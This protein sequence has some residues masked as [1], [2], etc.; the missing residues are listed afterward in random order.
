MWDRLPR[1]TLP[2]DI[3]KWRKICPGHNDIDPPLTT[4]SDPSPAP[5]FLDRPWS[6]MI[7]YYHSKNSKTYLLRN[8][9]PIIRSIWILFF[10]INE[11]PFD[12]SVKI[13]KKDY[14]T[15]HHQKVEWKR[16]GEIWLRP[17]LFLFLTN[18]R[19]GFNRGEMMSI[20]VE[21]DT[22]RPSDEDDLALKIKT[23]VNFD[24]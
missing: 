6:V 5:F 20:D 4:I 21:M 18:H 10:F 15:L 22:L 14:I 24:R 9:D 13:W 11:V 7:C 16:V 1:G 8:S 12:V 2:S 17:V 23:T 19:T 3:L